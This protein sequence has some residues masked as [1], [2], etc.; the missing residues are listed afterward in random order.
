MHE[1]D[2]KLERVRR[3]LAQHAADALLIRRVEN[4]AWA[5]CGAASYVSLASTDGNASLLVT[6]TERYLLT[7]NI[8]TTRLEREER[9]QDQGWEFRVA[10]WHQANSEVAE[11]SHGLR[12]AADAAYPDALDL[13]VPLAALRVSLTQEEDDRFISLGAVCAE[14]MDA[15]IRA[16]R[17]GLSEYQIAALLAA[18]TLSRGAQPIVNLIA[19][20][21]RVFQFR[22]PLPTAKRL[23]AYAMLVLCGRM[24]GLVCSITR[25]VHFGKMPD[26]LRRKMHAVAQVDAQFVAVTRPGRRL[27]DIFN[28]GI[29]CYRE[30]GFPDEW[31]LHHQGGVAG[32]LPREIIAT[33]QTAAI[34]ERGQAYAWNPS[35]TGTKSEDTILVGEKENRVL[36]EIAG[37]PSLPVEIAGR[38]IPRPVILELT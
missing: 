18:E 6:P 23:K 8:E 27:G 13:S 30:V 9:L 28:E 11:L 19:V 35:I 4:F 16:V 21:E 31:R 10:P 12:L 7:D 17:P 26:G 1:L 24:Q 37:W 22:H 29:A 3:L 15:S 38:V 34:V 25:L 33:P 14:A 2:Q 20:D 5:T 32:Y 36:T